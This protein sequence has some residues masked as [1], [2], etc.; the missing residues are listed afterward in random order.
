MCPLRSTLASLQDDSNTIADDDI[1]IISLQEDSN[2]ICPPTVD[3]CQLTRLDRSW[4]LSHS[5]SFVIALGHNF[6]ARPPFHGTACP[7]ALV[8]EHNF[9]A[10]LR[11]L[12]TFGVSESAVPV[13]RRELASTNTSSPAPIPR[14]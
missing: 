4:S 12:T 2:T 9:A 11:F 1:A 8:S 14:K 3:S 6:A 10:R 13:A 5:R 7:L